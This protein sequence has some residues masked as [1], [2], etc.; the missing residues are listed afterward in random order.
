M[1]PQY[2]AATRYRDIIRL[3]HHVSPVRTPMPPLNRAAQFAPFA[4]LTGYDAAIRETGRL[5]E[6]QR[7]LDESRKA[8]LDRKLQYLRDHMDE[9]P[10]VVITYF[11]PDRRKNGGAYVSAA[12]RVKK[13]R[14]A[15]RVILMADGTAIA[16]DRIYEV[17][18]DR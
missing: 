11:V 14:E 16:V 10:E 12:G 5:T 17:A 8:A 6:E 13:I 2:S 4:A 15:E 7:E 1:C 18:L 3:P 9:G